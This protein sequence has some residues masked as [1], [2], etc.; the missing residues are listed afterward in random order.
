MSNHY[1]QYYQTENLFGAPFPELMAFYAAIPKKGKLLDLGCGQGRD[2]IPLAKL[3]YEVLGIDAS[4]VGIEQMNTIAKD[5]NLTLTGL[6]GD[7]YTYSDFDQFDF[8]LLDSMFHFNK[9][10]RE[11]ETLLLKKIFEKSTP[12]ALITICIQ[13][14]GKKVNLLDSIIVET[15]QLETI[16]RETIKYK[17]EDQASKHSSETSYAI[18]T[19]KKL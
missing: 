9:K 18:I 17:F 13:K 3:G 6:V 15:P 4:K 11:Q 7:I 14:T 10:D 2:A 12:E 1:D 16:Q 8:I 5:E 19:L